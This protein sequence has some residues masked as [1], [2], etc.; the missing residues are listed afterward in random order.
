MKSKC[1]IKHRQQSNYDIRFADV[2]LC[3]H[4][5]STRAIV[6]ASVITRSERDLTDLYMLVSNGLSRVVPLLQNT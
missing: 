1:A 3:V 4:S 2:G 5:T 6:P